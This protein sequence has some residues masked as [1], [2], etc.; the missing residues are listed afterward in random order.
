MDKQADLGSGGAGRAVE[1]LFFHLQVSALLL[2]LIPPHLDG[3]SSLLPP[4]LSSS[5]PF[6]TWLQEGAF[7]N[8]KQTRLL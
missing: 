2:V 3:C 5:H 6:S 8:A 7:S 4:L 1:E